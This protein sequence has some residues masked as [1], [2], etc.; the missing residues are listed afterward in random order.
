MVI[1]CS[2]LLHAA[3]FY[4]AFES[5]PIVLFDTMAMSLLAVAHPI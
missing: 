3:A 1:I 4:I 2:M 5:F